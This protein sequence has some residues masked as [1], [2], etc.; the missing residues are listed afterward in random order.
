VCSSDLVHLKILAINDFHGQIT[1]GQTLDKRPVGGSPVLASYLNT[2]ITSEDADGVIIALPGDIVGASP[3][4]S[5][6]LRD[7]PT[8]LFFN[9]YANPYCSI[10][11][12][13]PDAS[14]NMVATLGNHEFDK[15]IPE[16]MRKIDGGDGATN[17]THLVDPYPGSRTTYVC[18]N[19][20]WKANMTPILPPYTLR[21]VSGVT[22]AFIGADTMET[23]RIQKSANI[24]D[25]VFLDEADSINRYIPEIQARGVHAIVVLL[26][27]GGSQAAYAGP[28]QANTTVTGR[29]ATIVPRLDSDVDVVLSGH[30][31]SF[32]NAYLTNAGGKTVLLTQAYKYSQGFADVDLTIDRA[33]GEILQ[34]SDRKSVV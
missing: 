33:T 32:T 25:V 1:P 7:E 3:P 22:V 11:S 23:P 2:A 19:V 17:I 9:S 20:V 18:S 8:M 6:L 31:H 16:L 10:G 24:E 5:G 4:A 34:K 27:E 13:P 14:C 28:T 30:T 26:H 15:G 29:V 12:N 21:N